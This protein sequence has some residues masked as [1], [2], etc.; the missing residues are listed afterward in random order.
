MFT[1]G[2]IPSLS[3]SNECKS[4]DAFLQHVLVKTLLKVNL[5]I[6]SSILS[7]RVNV[8]A[9]YK[10]IDCISGGNEVPYCLSG[11]SI[12]RFLPRYSS[13]VDSSSLIFIS[14]IL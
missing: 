13:Q 9:L 10:K 4:S 14:F 3:A 11:Y 1:V 2:N 8:Y 6:S 5:C 7:L 12:H